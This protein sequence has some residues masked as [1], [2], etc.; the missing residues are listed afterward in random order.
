MVDNGTIGAGVDP[1][2][3]TSDSVSALARYLLAPQQLEGYRIMQAQDQL[4]RQLTGGATTP[5]ARARFLAWIVGQAQ[6]LKVRVRG[7]HG[8][9]LAAALRLVQ[10]G[11]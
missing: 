1:D 9:S 4:W 2:G 6:H 5:Q 8:F 3:N 7:V 10:D 11:R